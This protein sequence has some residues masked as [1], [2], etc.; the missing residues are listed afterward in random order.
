MLAAPRASPAL[1]GRGLSPHS[2]GTGS[3]H[4]LPRVSLGDCSVRRRLPA[5][6]G[7]QGAVPLFHSHRR[8]AQQGTSGSGHQ[9]QRCQPQRLGLSSLAFSR[10]QARRR[11]RAFA[12]ASA[13]SRRYWRKCSGCAAIH[14]SGRS[15]ARST[16]SDDM[17]IGPSLPGSARMVRPN[18][19]AHSALATD[20]PSIDSRLSESPL[21]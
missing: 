1:G 6:V 10:R 2:S 7:R 21:R 15:D 3:G 17:A 12:A 19:Y 11:R 18:G 20:R 4:N 16:W 9:D 5:L 13:S 14:T 8:L